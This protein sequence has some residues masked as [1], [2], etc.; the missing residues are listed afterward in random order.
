[1]TKTPLLFYLGL[2]IVLSTS[3]NASEGARVRSFTPDEI[4]LATNVFYLGSNLLKTPKAEEEKLQDL[5]G[6][7]KGFKYKA[8]F[9]N[10]NSEDKHGG[11]F[12]KDNLCIVFVSGT[13][14]LAD[15]VTNI[16]M[17]PKRNHAFLKGGAH[18]GFSEDF[19]NLRNDPTQ[20][21]L[22]T[23]QGTTDWKNK[24]YILCGHSKGGAVVQLLALHLTREL[25]I[26]V[27]QTK[28]LT[29][30]APRIFDSEAQKDYDRTL[31]DRTL[32]VMAATDPIPTL[33]PQWFFGF[34]RTGGCLYIE[35]PED[36]PVHWFR[37]YHEAVE[38]M[39]SFQENPERHCY[40]KGVV[41]NQTRF[42]ATYGAK[43]LGE[44]AFSLWAFL[45]S[46]CKSRA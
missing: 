31:G 34:H 18:K 37:G 29:F 25:Q 14:I 5:Q 20:G 16:D 11:I 38:K 35:K 43:R 1:M 40:K 19:E 26:P 36:Y 30:G 39:V 9:G 42:N 3:A 12:H 7:L 41:W 8:V 13:V 33:P 17:Y 15:W 10:P 21:V 2:S 4:R 44:G 24:N 45:R 46:F 27:E 32:H 28:I 6:D 22:T 23:L